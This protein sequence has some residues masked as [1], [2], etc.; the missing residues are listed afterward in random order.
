MLV[1]TGG[2]VGVGTGVEGVLRRMPVLLDERLQTEDE[3]G[4]GEGGPGEGHGGARLEL[5]SLVPTPRVRSSGRTL[6]Q[7]RGSHWC[8]SGRAEARK[9]KLGYAVTRLNERETRKGLA[10][11]AMGQYGTI[12][13]S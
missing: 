7:G 10:S 2:V 1:S 11:N 5:W 6:G 3:C 4:R 9:R 12:L 8:F 13:L